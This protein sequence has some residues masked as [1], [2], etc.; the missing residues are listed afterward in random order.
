MFD[1]TDGKRPTREQ[2]AEAA[3]YR[4]ERR[5]WGD[6]GHNEDWAAV[7]KDLYFALNYRYVARH[8]LSGR[9]PVY[10]GRPES[11][12][13]RKPRRCR[14][15]EQAE[16]SVTFRKT[17]PVLPPIAGN[18]AL[19]AWDE[20]DECHGL[21]E[22]HLAQPFE[23]FARPLLGD[24]PAV[25]SGIPIAALKVL[26]RAGIAVLPAGELHHF[27]DTS[28]WVSNPDHDLDAMLLQGLGCRLYR[29]PEPVPSASIAVSRRVDEDARMP[30][31]M[32]FLA[33]A[34]SRI[35][36]QAVLPLCTRDEDLED[37]SLRGVELSMSL[38]QGSHHRASQSTFL[39]LIPP[40][41]I[42]IPIRSEAARLA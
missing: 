11:E 42:R 22:T 21:F 12:R 5:E 27:G 10:V 2:I 32:V 28:E 20:C 16:P 18:S 41:A 6:G 9:G 23:A 38:G 31:M 37:D 14:F 19:F 7:E 3:Y 26:V 30:Y 36:L 29:T 24:R 17:P 39:P 13:S 40:D 4:W 1:D 33:L 34:P 8:K 35:V 15:C 25:P